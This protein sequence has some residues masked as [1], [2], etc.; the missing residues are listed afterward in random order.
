M[1][2][3]EPPASPT[4]SISS[5]KDARVE[6][7]RNSAPSSEFSA[8]HR[9]FTT[10]TEA[11]RL[12][13]TGSLTHNLH[14]TQRFLPQMTVSRSTQN[15]TA[16]L[17]DVFSS[18]EYACSPV[19]DGSHINSSPATHL[20]F[21]DY[22]DLSPDAQRLT[23]PSASLLGKA[24]MVSPDGAL[25]TPAKSG[26]IYRSFPRLADYD[27][28]SSLE[29]KTP[30]VFRTSPFDSLTNVASPPLGMSFSPDYL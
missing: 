11:A 4:S 6:G 5:L 22:F 14:S 29:M 19:K 17:H 10:A 24:A 15:V 21:E 1:E 26:S 3:V 28:G 16:M 13:H 27:S 30:P 25:K 9:L 2:S 12:D 7:A 18:V 8:S 23:T 20:K